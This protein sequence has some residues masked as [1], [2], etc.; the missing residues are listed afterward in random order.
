ME[1]IFIEKTPD[2]KDKSVK[3]CGWVH[4]RRNHGKIIFI[5]L[6]DRSGILQVV[7]VP[8]AEEAYKLAE[9]LRSEWVVSIEGKINS[10]PKGMENPDIKTGLIEMQAGKLEIL[11]P[12]E[13]PPFSPDAD[14]YE[15]NEETRLKYRYIDLR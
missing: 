10:R 15:I 5:D 9:S 6:R 13:T 4:S 14:G 1:R 3:V 12:A 11:N 2:Y 7:F 8:Q